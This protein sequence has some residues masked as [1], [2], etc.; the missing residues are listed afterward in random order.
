LG[1]SKKLYSKLGNPSCKPNYRGDTAEEL[2][3]QVEE[4]EELK[5]KF[6]YPTHSIGDPIWNLGHLP[7]YGF[8]TTYDDMVFHCF[9]ATGNNGVTKGYN[10]LEMF[11]EKCKE[12]LGEK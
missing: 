7:P 6:I 9:G 1:L 11:I 4:K 8:G 2:T 3:W 5:L 12:V 10:I